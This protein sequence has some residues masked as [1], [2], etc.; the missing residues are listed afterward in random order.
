MVLYFIIFE[1]TNVV[2]QKAESPVARLNTNFTFA[3]LRAS[4]IRPAPGELPQ[5]RNEARVAGCSGAM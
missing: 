5:V 4:L 2:I 3:P 1:V